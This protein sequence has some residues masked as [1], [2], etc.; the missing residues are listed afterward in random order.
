MSANELMPAVK[1]RTLREQE[2]RCE[3]CLNPEGARYRV[4]TDAIDM[5]VCLPCAVEALRI[6]IKVEPLDVSK[7]TEITQ[8]RISSATQEKGGKVNGFQN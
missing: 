7:R 3:R 1:T 6:G 2:T 5:K 4:Y 8:G